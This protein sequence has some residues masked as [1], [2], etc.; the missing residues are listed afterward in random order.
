[1]YPGGVA[2]SPDGWLIAA[3]DETAPLVH[4]W[5][6]PEGRPFHTLPR[7]ELLDCLRTLTGLR[8]VSDSNAPGGYGT[9]S[10][11]FSGWEDAPTW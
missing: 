1:M 9:E 11:P 10:A 5:R 3:G 2:V 4:M 8:V 6:R 7:P